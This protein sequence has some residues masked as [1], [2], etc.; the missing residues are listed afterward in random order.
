MAIMWFCMRLNRKATN[1][2]QILSF[3]CIAFFEKFS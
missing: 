1:M 2:P 3:F